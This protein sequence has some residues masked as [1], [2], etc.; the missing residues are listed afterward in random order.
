MRIVSYRTTKHRHVCFTPP[1]SHHSGSRNRRAGLQ[2]N[3]EMH[4]THSCLC[5]YIETSIHIATSTLVRMGN[6]LL[7][8]MRGQVA[9]LLPTAIPQLLAKHLPAQTPHTRLQIPAKIP[10][11]GELLLLQE[12]LG[13]G[14][15][16]GSTVRRSWLEEMISS[17]RERGIV[18]VCGGQRGVCNEPF[19]WHT[20]ASQ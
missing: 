16:R 8:R 7:L 20:T 3:R 12:H 4:I 5:V 19:P 6:M 14:A 10:V 2:M 9:H 17:A 13:S 18:S 15:G 11:N 1:D